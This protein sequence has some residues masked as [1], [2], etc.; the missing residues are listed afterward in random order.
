M[1][2]FGGILTEAASVAMLTE[3]Y[4]RNEN[5]VLLDPSGY[6]DG[7]RSCAGGLHPIHLTAADSPSVVNGAEAGTR[8]EYATAGCD[9]PDVAR[10]R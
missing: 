8:Q 1:G 6:R 5:V 9:G 2:R 3:L 7:L 4:R 10:N